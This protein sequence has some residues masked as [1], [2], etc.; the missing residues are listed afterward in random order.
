MIEALVH[1]LQAQGYNVTIN[2]YA[3]DCSYAV[4]VEGS[5]FRV[6]GGITDSMLSAIRQAIEVVQQREQ[7][8]IAHSLPVTP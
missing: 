3:L 8:L 4:V 6:T 7:E 1:A 5:F 2:C